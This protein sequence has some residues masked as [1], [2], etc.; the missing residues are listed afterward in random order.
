MYGHVYQLAEAVA[1]ARP[2]AGGRSR[3]K[4]RKSSKTK[5]CPHSCCEIGNFKKADAVIFGTPIRF[6]TMCSQLRNF[7]DPTTQ[8]GLSGALVGKGGS[9]FVSTATQRGGQ[10]TTIQSFHTTRFHQRMIVVGV[11]YSEQRL[12]NMDENRRFSLWG[13]D[14]GAGGDG[15]ATQRK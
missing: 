10:E 7:L 11:P 13:N 9:V 3:K 12:L 4:R 6:G 15:A 2:D 1:G 14:S 5:F 8:L